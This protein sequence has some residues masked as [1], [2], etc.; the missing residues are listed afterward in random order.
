MKIKCLICED[1]IGLKSVHDLDLENMKQVIM[2]KEVIMH[3]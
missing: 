1:I 3:I 2:M